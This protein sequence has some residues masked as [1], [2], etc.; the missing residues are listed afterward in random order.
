MD[1][2]TGLLNGVRTSGAVFNQSFLSG[3]WALRF[4]DGSPMALAVLLRGSAWVIAKGGD[5]VRLDP[6][7]VAVLTGGAPYVIADDPAGRP[8]VVIRS[9][10]CTTA[11]GETTAAATVS[12]V[13]SWGTARP[14]STLLVSG[15]YT[16][17]SGMSRPLLAA[18]P[19]LAVV[20]AEVGVCPV[21]PAV[22]EEITR[23]AAGQQ[24]LLDRTLDLLLI[25][26]LRA[27]FT[28]PGAEI[29][30]WYTAH[31]DPVVGPAL[32]LL[33]TNPAHRWTL[34]ALAAKTGVSKANLVRRFTTLLG[35]PPMTYLRE[36]R[37]TMAAD[38]LREPDA[39]LAAVAPRVGFSTAFAL[40]AAF[41]RE[42]GISPSEYRTG[43]A[44]TQR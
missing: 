3:S 5:P 35:Q 43:T 9:E 2:L 34:E 20:K 11:D 22:F 17:D 36:W 1:P 7:D 44:P 13:G 6:G 8:T 32:R 14:D 40:S 4:E 25:T 16:V 23:E 30:A 28:R 33:H 15:L 39:T 26:A 41:K 31:A 21:S 38:L 10:G 18:L 37:L 24:A 12:G 42:R 19:P 29:P 27:W